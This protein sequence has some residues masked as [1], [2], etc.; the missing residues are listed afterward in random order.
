MVFTILTFRQAP[1]P[2]DLCTIAYT[3]GTTGSPKGVMLSHEN[4]VAAISASLLQ[5]GEQQPTCEDTMISFLPLAHMLELCCEVRWWDKRWLQL[6]GQQKIRPSTIKNT[7]LQTI[8]II[9]A[10][11]LSR[12]TEDVPLTILNYIQFV[13]SVEW[14]NF[15]SVWTFPT[16]HHFRKVHNDG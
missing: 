1:K 10:S 4:I 6:A 11:T 13:A 5:L 3:S 12:G 2:G 7:I 8:T 9:V 15:F 14:F 16:A